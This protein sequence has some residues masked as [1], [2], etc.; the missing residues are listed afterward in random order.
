MPGTSSL[1]TIHYS[2]I[3]SAGLW[4]PGAGPPPH[5]GARPPHPP[6]GPPVGGPT[7][8]VCCRTGETGEILQS[9]PHRSVPGGHFGS[10]PL[11]QKCAGGRDRGRARPGKS[12]PG[13]F[14]DAASLG[15]YRGAALRNFRRACGSCAGVRNTVSVGAEQRRQRHGTGAGGIACLFGRKQFCA[16]AVCRGTRFM[17]LHPFKGQGALP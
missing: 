17:R 1:F 13:C 16:R 14:P 6:G 10:V 2:L 12:R 9:P 3:D 7:P 15:E 5:R 11:L 8:G 4:K